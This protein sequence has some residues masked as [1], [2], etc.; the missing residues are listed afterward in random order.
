M[1]TVTSSA[2][3][4]QTAV[5]TVDEREIIICPGTHAELDGTDVAR[6]L[7]S[8]VPGGAVLLDG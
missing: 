2:A 5:V 4:P 1:S 7:R 6:G 8:V 3:S